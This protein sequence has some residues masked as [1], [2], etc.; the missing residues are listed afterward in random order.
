MR[1]A[2]LADIHCSRHSH[3][4]LRPLFTRIADSADVVLLCGDLIDYGLPEEAIILAKEIAGIKI[5]ALAVLGNHEFESGKQEDVKRIFSDA[6][7]MILD[8]DAH[9]VHGGRCENLDGCGRF[10][11][12]NS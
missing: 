4:S 11:G 5:P 7:V 8:G 12:Q 9:E 3:D 6:G 2:A 1:I 10:A